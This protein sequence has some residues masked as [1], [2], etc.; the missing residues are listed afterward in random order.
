LRLSLDSSQER[1]SSLDRELK[2]VND[3]LEIETARFGD[4]LRC[5]IDVAPELRS[6]II[7]TLVLQ[8]L[9]ENSVKHAVASRFEGAFIRVE[10]YARGETVVVQVSDDGPG[11]TAAAIRPGHGLDNVQRRMAAL[12]GSE[13]TMEI[14]KSGKFT[15]VSI[16]LPF[17]RRMRA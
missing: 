6:A 9:V 11:F 10:A 14:S 17:S 4:R 16:C 3:Y 13:G 5:A 1:L 8:T 15:A 12:F 7:P 2:I